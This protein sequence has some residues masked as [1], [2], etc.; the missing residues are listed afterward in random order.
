MATWSSVQA[1]LRLFPQART[2]L[3]VPHLRPPGLAALRRAGEVG[4]HRGALCMGPQLR[5]PC[6]QEEGLAVVV[7]CLVVCIEDHLVV[8]GACELVADRPSGGSGAVVEAPAVDD[9][10][11]RTLRCGAEARD[12][13]RRARVMV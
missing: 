6:A 9:V 13:R 1:R 7:A 10:T 12:Q 3:G 8:A 5:R 2:D 4:S 11:A